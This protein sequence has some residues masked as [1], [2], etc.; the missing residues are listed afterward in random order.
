MVAAGDT[1]LWFRTTKNYD[2]STG[3]LASCSLMYLLRLCIHSLTHYQDSGK[4]SNYM[5]GHQAVLNHSVKGKEE[6]REIINN[7][8]FIHEKR[9]RR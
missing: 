7:K 5:L 6:V 1:P 2:V 4:L 8:K 9:Q 3:S